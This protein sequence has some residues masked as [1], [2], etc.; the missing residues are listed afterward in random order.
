MLVALKIQSI[1]KALFSIVLFFI[2]APSFAQEKELFSFQII[3]GKTKNPVSYATIVLNNL[4]KGTHAD[5]NGIVYL[6][7]Y[8]SENESFTISAIG[9]DSAVFSLLDFQKNKINII[10]INASVILLEEIKIKTIRKRKSDKKTV[11]KEITAVGIIQKAIENIPL[12]YPIEPHAYIAHYRDYQQP[13]DDIYIKSKK[14]RE[15]VNYINLNEGIIEVFDEGFLSDPIK[16]DKNQIALYEYKINN[17]YLI[18]STLLIPYDNF[19][20]KFTKTITIQPFGG[21]EL[22]ILNVTNPIRNYNSQSVSFINTLNKDFVNNHKFKLE[23]FQNLNGALLYEISFESLKE[24]TSFLHT[25]KGKIFIAKNNFAI[26]KLNYSLFLKDFEKPKYSINLEYKS[27]EN[28]MYLDYIAFNNYVEFANTEMTKLERYSFNIDNFSFVLKFN[29][30]INFATIKPFRKN[31]KLYFDNKRFKILSAKNNFTNDLV[32]F[33]RTLSL[34]TKHKKL[35][36]MSKEEISAGSN[37]V[38][39]S[40]MRVQLGDILDENGFII[41]KAPTFKMYQFREIFVQKIF[42]DKELSKDKVFINKKAP[43]FKAKIAPFDFKNDF[44]INTPLR[45]T[46]ED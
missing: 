25:A 12:N 8:V 38:F 15:K 40:R 31:L 16:N 11:K 9:Y 13:I 27:V 18:D 22:N 24:K 46:I 42:K 19:N 14:I 41:N 10:S 34:E 33:G 20:K 36:K 39:F 26:Y 1:K 30:P 6:P 35:A 17:R 28:K 44:W 7:K 29:N 45:K 5:F 21:N 23:G 4:N 32:G 43:L 37:E 3:D 2:I